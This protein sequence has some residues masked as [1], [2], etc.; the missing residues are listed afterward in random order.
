MEYNFLPVY[1]NPNPPRICSAA[2]SQRS[3]KIMNYRIIYFIEVVWNGL[4]NT[5]ISLSEEQP[6]T[7]RDIS[8]KT[9]QASELVVQ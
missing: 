8:C 5:E 6:L 3:R 2:L 1:E 7:T 4:K 9:T